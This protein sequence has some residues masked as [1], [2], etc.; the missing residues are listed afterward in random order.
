MET[1]ID[2]F[3]F[4]VKDQ[5]G[6]TVNLYTRIMSTDG[7][8]FEQVVKWLAPADGLDVLNVNGDRLTAFF[9]KQD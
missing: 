3:T 4:T 1:D 7:K 6:K 8:M 9:E 2:T 5:N